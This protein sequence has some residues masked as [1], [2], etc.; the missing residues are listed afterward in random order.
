MTEEL[1]IER[2]DAAAWFTLN[3]ANDLNS[4]NGGLL[5]A[6][7]AG[8]TEALTNQSVRTVVFTGAGR[9]FCAGADL[10]FIDS[11]PEQDR[12]DA[13]AAFLLAATTLISRIATSPKPT[14]AA[15]NGV[16]V[17]GGLELLLACDIILAV[18]GAPIG[19]GHANYGL[20]PGAGSSIRLPRRIGIGRAKQLLFTGELLP[21]ERWAEFGLVNEVVDPGDLQA[22]AHAVATAIAAK[23]PIGLA[24][25]KQIVDHAFDM[26]ESAGLA[27]EQALC[28]LHTTSFDRNEGLAAFRERRA[29]I[30]LGR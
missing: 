6:L 19:D 27:L 11:L 21:A 22:R 14:I 4:L 18:R 17:G 29:P 1:T 16:A 13:T 10:K 9:A 26:S 12:N 30:F 15:V 25:M 28:N 7:E 8:L 20:L 3:R 5:K 24:R 2:R 23:S